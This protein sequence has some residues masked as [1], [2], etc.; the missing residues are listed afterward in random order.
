MTLSSSETI[1]AAERGNAGRFLNHSCDPNCETQKWMVNGELCIGIYALEDIRDAEELT[2]DYNFERYG[3]NPIKCFCGTTKC[4]GWIGGGAK[5]GEEVV[6][7][8]R[9][10]VDDQIGDVDEEEYY[11]P[12]PVMLEAD[13][14]KIALEETKGREA[15]HKQRAGGGSGRPTHLSDAFGNTSKKD[16]YGN[17]DDDYDGDGEIALRKKELKREESRAQREASRG[18][19]GARVSSGSG[20]RRSG[21]S[22]VGV[23]GGARRTGSIGSFG[24]NRSSGA[25]GYNSA[26]YA[27]NTMTRRSEVDVSMELLRGKS[28]ALRNAK[29]AVKCVHLFNLAYPVL[30][31]GTQSVSQ[32]DLGL[33]LE[34][35]AL[36]VNP[37]TQQVLIEKGLLQVRPCGAFPNP[38]TLFTAPA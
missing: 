7:G 30:K 37:A 15:R 31:D 1:D 35:V 5:D 9:T 16:N 2:F 3:D 22:S 25:G 13:E 4:G 19:G 11:E 36:T 23:G 20:L 12:V 6:G 32:R 28:G 17:D 33:L 8:G 26:A 14:T 27:L 38:G 34:A 21:S 10:D 18:T 24:K 29:A